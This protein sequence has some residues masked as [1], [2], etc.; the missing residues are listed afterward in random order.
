MLQNNVTEANEAMRK[1]ISGDAV[2]GV[3][4]CERERRENFIVDMEKSHENV[5]STAPFHCRSDRSPNPTSSKKLRIEALSE[6]NHV[7]YPA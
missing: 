2:L 4:G 7:L 1:N 5:T 3:V 6:H